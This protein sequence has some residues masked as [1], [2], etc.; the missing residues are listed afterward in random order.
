MKERIELTDSAQDIVVKMSNGNPGAVTVCMRCLK[1]AGD[2]DPTHFAG[3][4]GPLL[5][6]GS[7]GL[8]GS[9]I[10]M[11]YKDVCNHSLPHMIALLRAWQT[12]IVTRE[13]LMGAIGNTGEGLNVDRVCE[14]VCEQ[15]PNFNM[16]PYEK[17]EESE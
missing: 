12:G 8:Y 15:L 2:I 16:N 13:D 5:I 7:L 11:L 6:M 1:E 14:Q 4:F 17:N 9:G 3:S 10:W